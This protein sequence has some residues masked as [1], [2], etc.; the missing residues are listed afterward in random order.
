MSTLQ[1]EKQVMTLNTMSRKHEK[2]GNTKLAG[3]LKSSVKHFKKVCEETNR[4][5]DEMA[6]GNYETSSTSTKDEFTHQ[7]YAYQDE[8]AYNFCGLE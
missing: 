2:A 5:L 8:Y 3:W 6:L 4:M 1:L 7:W